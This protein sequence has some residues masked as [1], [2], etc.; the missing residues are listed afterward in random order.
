MNSGTGKGSGEQIQFYYLDDQRSVRKTNRLPDGVRN[1]V[2]E[3]HEL[4]DSET[5]VFTMARVNSYETYEEVLASRD[6]LKHN[7]RTEIAGR[8][9]G[10]GSRDADSADGFQHLVNSEDTLK[11]LAV[12]IKNSMPNA[13][14][15]HVI[16]DTRFADRL[17][18]YHG[19]SKSVPTVKIK[20][21]EG[22]YR[23]YL[24]ENASADEV[25]IGTI[26]KQSD[27]LILSEMY[28]KMLRL[29]FE[30]NSMRG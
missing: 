29:S 10:G 27:I 7:E 2:W 19:R 22:A 14:A 8:L 13:I 1:Y 26:L 28:E 4:I 15:D 23:I 25:N 21:V 30:D 18:L 3:S 6:D 5:I 16:V 24:K 9:L 11:S 20:W 17:L 12:T